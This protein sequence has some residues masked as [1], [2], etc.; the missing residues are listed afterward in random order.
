MSINNLFA[1]IKEKSYGVG[2]VL[3]VFGCAGIAEN[4]TSNRGSFLFS[5]IMFAIGFSLVLTSYE[6]KK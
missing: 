4:I 5:A 6:W 2:V 1:F 3:T